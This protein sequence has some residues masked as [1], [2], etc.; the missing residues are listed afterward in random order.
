MLK[1]RGDFIQSY[2]DRVETPELIHS[3]TSLKQRVGEF[4][5]AEEG[6]S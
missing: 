1:G 4:L 5:R 2:C 6:V 3:S